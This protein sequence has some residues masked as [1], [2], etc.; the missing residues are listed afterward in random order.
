VW[1]HGCSQ[2]AA[3]LAAASRMD[4]LAAA[5]RLIVVAPEQPASANQIRCWNWFLPAH[6]SRGAGE[7]AIIAAIAREVAAEY[8]A[9]P[10]RIYVGGLSAGAAMAVVTA[11]AYPELFAAA[12]SHSGVGWRMAS[13]VTGGLAVMKSGG[14]H[15]DSLGTAALQSMGEHAWAIPLFVVHGMKDAVVTPVAS[16]N[17]VTQF[18]AI[19]RR[20]GVAT[21][22]DSSGGEAG[23]YTYSV[24]RYRDERDRV[25]IEAWFVDSLGHALSG[26]AAGQPWTDPRGP[27]A[28][29]EMLRFFLDHPRPE[30]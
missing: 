28:T 1:L 20:S 14:G 21:D 22:A 7:P 12:G 4:S 8:G 5:R 10:R 11:I 29:G 9:D 18:A 24:L 3:S 23:G 16:G 27:D 13:D 19:A 2:D 15:A 6:Q 26:G 25:L 17:L 30:R